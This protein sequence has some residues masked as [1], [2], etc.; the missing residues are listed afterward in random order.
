MHENEGYP[1]T[2]AEVLDE[3]MTFNPSALRA[4]KAFAESKPWRGTV[5]E[6]REKFRQVNAALSA[7]YGISTPALGFADS[8]D[9]DSGSSFYRP[10]AHAITL[11]GLSVVTLLHEFCHARKMGERSATR[12]STNM[13]RRVWPRS[14]A[15]CVQDGHMLR[16]RNDPSGR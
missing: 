1:E 16:R 8:S 14:F 13:F 10:S 2:I 5:D 4:V 3:N 15:R 11:T 7:A 12:W 6:R 9:G